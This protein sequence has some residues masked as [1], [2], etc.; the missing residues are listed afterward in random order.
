MDNTE[1][2]NAAAN[3]QASEPLNEKAALEEVV[4]APALTNEEFQVKA[5]AEYRASLL[6]P[7][8]EEA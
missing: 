7:P 2:V 3:F 4:A 1:E 8:V 6:N 5:A